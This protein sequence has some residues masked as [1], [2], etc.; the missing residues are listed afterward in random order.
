MARTYFCASCGWKCR[1]ERD[2]GQC[3]GCGSFTQR[4]QTAWDGV[5]SDLK[6]VVAFCAVFFSIAFIGTW[7]M[8]PYQLDGANDFTARF[9]LDS[10]SLMDSPN[11]SVARLSLRNDSQWEM[12]RIELT[13]RIHAI[14]PGD[15]TAMIAV[16]GPK[17]MV[18]EKLGPNSEQFL[19]FPVEG[20]KA[21]ELFGWMAKIESVRLAPGYWNKRLES[22]LSP[23]L[24]GQNQND[25][26]PFPRS[27]PN[28][29]LG[30]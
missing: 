26:V 6:K 1:K 29:H 3:P 19:D 7:L 2:P 17:L 18:V 28:R 5:V 30:K 8:Y 20:R 9:Q 24:I 25:L 16:A 27:F 13:L 4:Y 22:A 23:R 10:V 12:A 21:G 11:G 15:Q 14:A